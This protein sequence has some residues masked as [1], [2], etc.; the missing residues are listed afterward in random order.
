MDFIYEMDGMIYQWDIPS[1]DNPPIHGE[2]TPIHGGDISINGMQHI[3]YET[4]LIDTNR[5]RGRTFF[6][7]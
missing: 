1:M 6:R 3:A 2:D 4:P 7:I 5:L